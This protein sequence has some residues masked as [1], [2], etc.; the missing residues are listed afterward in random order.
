MRMAMALHLMR[1]GA[2]P[3]MVLGA[4][5]A[6]V[7]RAVIP[8]IGKLWKCVVPKA[9]LLLPTPPGY[10]QLQRGAKQGND[11]LQDLEIGPILGYGSY[12]QVFEGADFPFLLEKELRYC[13][14]RHMTTEFKWLKKHARS[15]MAWS[16][17]CG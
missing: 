17:R 14:H 13:C 7:V 8:K 2:I 6:E 4:L 3:L 5:S 12:G 1:F 9:E 10:E 11:G 15:T 16:A